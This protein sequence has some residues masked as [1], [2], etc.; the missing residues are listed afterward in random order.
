LGLNL[1]VGTGLELLSD[2]EVIAT[3]LGRRG[4]LDLAALKRR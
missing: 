4:R 1:I 3:Y 2:Q